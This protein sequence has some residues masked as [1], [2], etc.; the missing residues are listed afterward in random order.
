VSRTIEP[1]TRTEAETD[2][3][4]RRA[5]YVTLGA[6]ATAAATTVSM[7]AI[8]LFAEPSPAW[9]AIGAVGIAAF[10]AAQGAALYATVTPWLADATRRRLRLAY[11]LA[12]LLSVP[13]VG[14]VAADEWETWAWIG[15]SVAGTA[16]LLLDRRR[17]ALVIAGLGVLTAA[18]AWR[19]GDSVLVSVLLAASMAAS[20]VAICTLPAWLWR[21]LEEAQSGREEQAH[22]AAAE[23]RLR[24]ARDVHDVLGH[25]LTVIALKGE[26]VARLAHV[27]ADR[28]AEE[29]EDVRR[30]A[31]TALA[32]VRSAV[33][34]Y[35]AVDLRDQLDA[36]ERVMRSCGIRCTVTEPREE[37]PAEVATVLA[38][39]PREASTN[40]LRHSKA[41]WCTIEIARDADAIRLTVA[42]DGAADA[43]GD[44]TSSGIRG[45][46]DRVAEAGGTLRTSIHDGVF[47]LEAAIGDGA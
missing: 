6:L 31:S 11:A 28:A 44:G 39:V 5:R 40:I 3:R 29:A 1:V 18:I 25:N 22:P 43:T 33:H 36:I 21:L 26:L 23:E 46:R 12:T 42:N 35:R 4:L 9:I 38:A 15:G 2:P 27:D 10:G 8:G 41:R 13:L 7:A 14:P 45:L 19:N 34:G 37:L 24:F 17:A 47:T 16:P 20:I 30:L 32:E